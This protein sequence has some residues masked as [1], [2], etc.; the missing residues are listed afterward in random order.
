MADVA[1]R[2]QLVAN[3]ANA[4]SIRHNK[5]QYATVHARVALRRVAF[6]L[7]GLNDPLVIP[8]AWGTTDPWG[9]RSSYLLNK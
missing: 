6:R 5:R 1:A 3:P 4:D 7:S 8:D 2:M 9:S